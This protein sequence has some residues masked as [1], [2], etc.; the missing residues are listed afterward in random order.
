MNAAIQRRVKLWVRWS[1]NTSEYSNTENKKS[2]NFLSLFYLYSGTE[3]NRHS[4][5]CEQ[6]F[7][8][9]VSTSSTTRVNTSKTQKTEP[10]IEKKSRQVGINFGAEDRARTGHLDLGKVALYQMSYFRNNDKNFTY[11]SEGKN[12]CCIATIK[13]FICIWGC[14]GY[15]KV[16]QPWVAPCTGAYTNYSIRPKQKPAL[17]KPGKTR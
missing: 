13:I 11:F 4:H 14:K 6:D 8:S 17:R 12:K 5:Y 15:W 3:L 9:C 7:K 2:G 10:L 16:F 1:I